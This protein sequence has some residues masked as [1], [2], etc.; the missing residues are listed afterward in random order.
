MEPYA[1]AWAPEAHKP[2]PE[3]LS[4][5]HQTEGSQGKATPSATHG[6]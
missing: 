4:D 3:F 1:M 2:W 5:A 6:R